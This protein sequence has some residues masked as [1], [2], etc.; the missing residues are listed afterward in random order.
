MSL[1]IGV[2]GWPRRRAEASQQ[3]VFWQRAS[4]DPHRPKE[5]VTAKTPRSNEHGSAHWF[6]KNQNGMGVPTLAAVLATH[7]RKRICGRSAR[8]S[9]NGS[10]DDLARARQ[11]D[12]FATGGN[13][14]SNLLEIGSLVLC[15]W[16]LI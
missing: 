1:F 6:A 5:P 14:G 11:A 16:M 7:A 8:M 9:R 15:L 4:W 12:A 3:T 13:H 10:D 2:R